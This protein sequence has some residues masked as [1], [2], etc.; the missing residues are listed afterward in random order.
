MLVLG[1]TVPT[2]GN[3]GGCSYLYTVPN[4]IIRIDIPQQ[5][6]IRKYEIDTESLKVLLRCSKKQSKISNRQIAEKLNKPM[7]LVEHWFR[8]DN[9]FSIPDEDI[10]YQLKELLSITTTEFD[11]AIT[12]FEIREGVYEKSNRC[13]L[14]E[15][16]AP[17]ITSAS[18]DEKIIVKDRSYRENLQENNYV[19]T[20]A[21]M[22][23]RYNKDGKIEQQLELRND[24]ISNAITTVQKDSLVVERYN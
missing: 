23:G 14:E 19:V 5:V 3:A 24:E 13:Y 7:T 8:K 9:C 2:V 22:R 17:T 10:W 18:A 12:T 20:P 1:N 15:G 6:K 21:A 4:E 16:I 11:K